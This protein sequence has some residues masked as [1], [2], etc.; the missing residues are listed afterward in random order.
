M[1]IGANIRLLL[2]VQLM[3]RGIDIILMCEWHTFLRERV[4]FLSHV[5]TTKIYMPPPMIYPNTLEDAIEYLFR[6]VIFKE[7]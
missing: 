2:K 6:H 1:F 4:P 3:V 5:H 7:L